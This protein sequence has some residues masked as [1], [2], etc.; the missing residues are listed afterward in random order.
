MTEDLSWEEKGAAE[1]R[2]RNG[3][4]PAQWLISK[5]PLDR[6]PSRTHQLAVFDVACSYVVSPGNSN[7]RPVSDIE[8]RKPKQFRRALSERLLQ[9]SRVEV[10]EDSADRGG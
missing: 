6:L 5:L 7:V 1:T 10:V 4:G 9:V 2:I 8:C 3:G